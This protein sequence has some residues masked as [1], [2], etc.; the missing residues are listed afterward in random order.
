MDTLLF[1][2]I[3]PMKMHP[4]QGDAIKSLTSDSGLSILRIKNLHVDVQWTSRT[5]HEDWGNR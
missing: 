4:E 5:S 1:G 2:W 3:G